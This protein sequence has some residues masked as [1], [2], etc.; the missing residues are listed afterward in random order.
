MLAE[1]KSA[2]LMEAGSLY[3]LFLESFAVLDEWIVNKIKINLF[4][5]E[6]YLELWLWYYSQV[7]KWKN[8]YFLK[9]E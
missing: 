8:T 1:G 2:P 3:V 7:V 9:D 6:K 4:R 5:I